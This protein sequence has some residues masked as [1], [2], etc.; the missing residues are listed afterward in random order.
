MGKT[1]K[2]VLSLN[3]HDCIELLAQAK[4]RCCELVCPCS[5]IGIVP[6]RAIAL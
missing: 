2:I 4:S 1:Y 3:A 6:P 5:M